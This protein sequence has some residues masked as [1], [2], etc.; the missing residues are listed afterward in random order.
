MA[1]EK[2]LSCL[3][4]VGVT[5]NAPASYVTL[6]GQT[7]TQFDGSVQIADTTDKSNNGWQTGLATTRSGTVSVNGNL[8]TTR[9]QLDALETAWVNGTTHAC[10]IVF[11][12][13][14]GGYTGSFYITAFNISGSVSDVTKYSITLT[15]AAALT[16]VP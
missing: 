10:K 6:E 7:D 5:A 9:A 4:Q 13:S 3:L 11:D 8:Y 1:N 12:A 15:P 2:G 14:G 16:A